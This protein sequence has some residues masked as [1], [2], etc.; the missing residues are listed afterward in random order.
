MLSS[1]LTNCVCLA[2]P[3]WGSVKGTSGK[4]MCDSWHS[5]A[6]GGIIF[7]YLAVHLRSLLSPFI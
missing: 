2:V 5:D 1:I 4:F 3:G 6:G 7:K